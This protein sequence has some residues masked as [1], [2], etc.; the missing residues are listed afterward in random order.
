MYTKDHSFINAIRAAVAGMIV[1][2]ETFACCVRGTSK[3][4]GLPIQP[5]SETDE[6]PSTVQA[7][8]VQTAQEVI[9]GILRDYLQVSKVANGVI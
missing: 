7:G 4:T 2:N 8:R 9:K 3:E 1:S 5:S 6:S